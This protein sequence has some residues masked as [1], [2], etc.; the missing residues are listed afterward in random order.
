M[1]VNNTTGDSIDFDTLADAVD[2]ALH[3]DEQEWLNSMSNTPGRGIRR[4]YHFCG[5]ELLDYD[6]CYSAANT[7]SVSVKSDLSAWPDEFGNQ[8][9]PSEFIRKL[10]IKNHKPFNV[11]ILESIIL[12]D[13]SV[14]YAEVS[15]QVDA[16]R[17]DFY[18]WVGGDYKDRFAYSMNLTRLAAAEFCEQQGINRAT[19]GEVID[20]CDMNP[21]RNEVRIKVIA[22]P[23]ETM[24]RISDALNGSGIGRVCRFVTDKNLMTKG[25]DY[26]TSREQLKSILKSQYRMMEW[27]SQAESFIPVSVF[28]HHKECLCK[29]CEYEHY[30][31]ISKRL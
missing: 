5:R 24:R 4:G 11:N 6:T 20:Y 21:E 23:F 17:L 1:D 27:C 12:N 16:G 26:N 22:G 28:A 9:V 31:K 14:T 18:L 19:A 25:L 2:L 13:T 10:S 7:G 3:Y 30:T 29:Y 8:I 15:V